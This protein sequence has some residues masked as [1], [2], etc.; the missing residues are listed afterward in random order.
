MITSG[1]LNSVEIDSKQ[2]LGS[3]VIMGSVTIVFNANFHE[4]NYPLASIKK[5]LEM[6]VLPKSGEQVGKLSLSPGDKLYS[7]NGRTGTPPG[8][9]Q[10]YSILITGA[11]DLVL[12]FGQERKLPASCGSA[13]YIETLHSHVLA[14][15]D[16]KPEKSVEFLPL[17]LELVEATTEYS[18]RL[19]LLS[20]I[21]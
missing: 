21:T 14:T 19:D 15:V 17:D 10:N 20:F 3:S 13:K 9:L 18:A 6:F 1:P 12:K 16:E 5:G 2:T 4:D 8:K 7:V 11:Q